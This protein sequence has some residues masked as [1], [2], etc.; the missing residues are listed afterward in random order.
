MAFDSERLW[1][2][3]L[4]DIVPDLPSQVV[5]TWFRPLVPQPATQP[6]L[7]LL[8]PNSFHLQCVQER[9]TKLLQQ[10]VDGRTAV[11]TPV[12]IILAPASCNVPATETPATAAAT[13]ANVLVTRVPCSTG[14]RAQQG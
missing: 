1:T 11:S 14:S 13:T 9:Y 8:A 2:E 4:G 6:P 10:K 3:V 5:D 12:E 7:R